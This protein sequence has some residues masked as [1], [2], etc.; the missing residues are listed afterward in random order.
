MSKKRLY[1]IAKEMGRP[2]KEVVEYAQQLGI[3]VKSHSSS[4]EEADVKRIVAKLSES[5]QTPPSAK[6]AEQ[7]AA[8]TPEAS[9]AKLTTAKPKSRNFK[10]ERELV[11]KHK[12]KNVRMRIKVVKNVIKSKTATTVHNSL[13]SQQGMAKMLKEGIKLT[14]SRLE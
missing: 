13:L 12:L 5:K 14:V 8:K 2:S 11:R 9:A 3:A 10:A 7:L 4:V 1:E 6:S